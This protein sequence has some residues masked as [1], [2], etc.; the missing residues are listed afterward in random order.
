MCYLS[1]YHDHMVCLFHHVLCP[2]HQMVWI[3]EKL[4]FQTVRIVWCQ[5]TFKSVCNTKMNATHQ[6]ACNTT[7]ARFNTKTRSLAKCHNIVDYHQLAALVE[8]ELC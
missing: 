3:F 2:L 4:F 7:P 8:G 1:I 5:Y 6:S